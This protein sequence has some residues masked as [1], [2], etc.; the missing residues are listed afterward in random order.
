MERNTQPEEAAGVVVG[1]VGHLAQGPDRCHG[2][3]AHG[4]KRARKKDWWRGEEPRKE[5]INYC[6]KSQRRVRKKLPWSQGWAAWA[7]A[8]R[9]I[10]PRDNKDISYSEKM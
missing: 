7:E 9:P 4:I 10:Q 3:A 8:I 1:E 5:F 6:R 2:C